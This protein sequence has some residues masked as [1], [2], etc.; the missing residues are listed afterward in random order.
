MSETAHEKTA[1]EVRAD[2]IAKMARGEIT[3]EEYRRLY[4]EY[5]ARAKAERAGKGRR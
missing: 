4:E 3:R 2:A 1:D 5:C